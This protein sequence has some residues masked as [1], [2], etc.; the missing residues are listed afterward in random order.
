MIHYV[1]GI[2]LSFSIHNQCRHPL[3][4]CTFTAKQREDNVSSNVLR[5]YPDRVSTSPQH[6]YTDLSM[7]PLRFL[8]PRSYSS[9]SSFEHLL[10]HYVRTL[11]SETYSSIHSPTCVITSCILQEGVKRVRTL[12]ETLMQMCSGLNLSNIDLVNPFGTIR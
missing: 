4:R 11:C 8:F 5:L 2:V 6:F 10:E 3:G 12:E 9:S 7:H 1:N